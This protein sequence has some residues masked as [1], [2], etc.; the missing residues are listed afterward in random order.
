MSERGS[1]EDEEELPQEIMDLLNAAMD[2]DN[3]D[4]LDTSSSTSESSSDEEHPLLAF[5]SAPVGSEEAMDTAGPTNDQPSTSRP[6]SSGSDVSNISAAFS[7]V[8]V[9]PTRLEEHPGREPQDGEIRVTVK[10]LDDRETVIVIGQNEPVQALLDRARACFNIVTGSQKII[11][12]GRVIQGHTTIQAA[13][14]QNGNTVHI[15]ERSAASQNDRPNIT[16]RYMSGPAIP[17]HEIPAVI[18]RATALQAAADAEPNLTNARVRV[19]CQLNGATVLHTRFSEEIIEQK[20]L[21]LSLRGITGQR[22]Q[23]HL[24]PNVF[25]QDPNYILWNIKVNEEPWLRPRQS[26]EQIVRQTL[27]ELPFLPESTKANVQFKWDHRHSVLTIHFPEIMPHIASPALERMD[28]LA[29]WTEHLE[30]F[31]NKLTENDGLIAAVKQVLELTRQQRHE[32]D[33]TQAGVA[34][35]LAVLDA[36]ITELEQKWAGLSHLKDYERARFRKNQHNEDYRR[37]KVEEI[38]DSP[39]NPRYYMRHALDTELH[40]VIRHYRQQQRRFSELEELL[41]DLNQV[42]AIKFIKDSMHTTLDY[43]SRALSIFY[44][45]MQRMRHQVAHMSHLVSELDV[46]FLN[47]GCPQR[48]LPQYAPNTFSIP[49]PYCGSLSFQMVTLP[50][51]GTT[52][53]IPIREVL[54]P[55]RVL[56]DVANRINGDWPYLPYHP[57]SIFV[58]AVRAQRQPFR[59]RAMIPAGT[60][61]LGQVP[62]GGLLAGLP[63]PVPGTNGIVGI[64]V[65]NPAPPGMPQFH[66]A[67]PSIPIPTPQAG[68]DQQVITTTNPNDPFIGTSLADMM[69]ASQDTL[70]ALLNQSIPP[71]ERPGP[72]VTNVPNQRHRRVLS[73]TNGDTPSVPVE[74][75]PPPGEAARRYTTH[76]FN[77]QPDARGA[78]TETLAPF[79]VQI[80]PSELQRIA[81]NIASRYREDALRRIAAM[82]S[83]RFQD[84]SWDTRLQN[85]PMCTMRECI[86]VALELLTSSG[87]TVDESKNL[88]LALVRDEE[89]LVRAVTECVKS[90]FGRGE[91]PTHVAR[92]ILPRDQQAGART[93]YESDHL[94]EGQSDELD[95]MIVRMPSDISQP[96]S[97]DLRAIRESRMRRRQLAESRNVAGPSTSAASISSAPSLTGPSTSASSFGP[98]DTADIRNGRLPLG[99]RRVRETVHPTPARADSPSQISVTFTASNQPFMHGPFLPPQPGPSSVNL[100]QLP[101]P[102]T[103]WPNPM[104][105]LNRP[106]VSPTPTTRGLLDYDISE[107]ADQVE[108]QGHP[109]Q[110]TPSS[111]PA[112]PSTSSAGALPRASSAPN[113]S[114]SSPTRQNIM[115]QM[116]EDAARYV[117]NELGLAGFVEGTGVH[118]AAARH[119]TPVPGPPEPRRPHGAQEQAI[120]IVNRRIE[121]R[122]MVAIDPFMTCSNRLC[123]INTMATVPNQESERLTHTSIRPDEDFMR[124]VQTL[125][126]SI[127]RRPVL[128]DDQDPDYNYNLTKCANGELKFNDAPS[129]K[130][131]IRTAVRSLMAHCIDSDTVHTMNMAPIS[132]FPAACHV[133][134]NKM[135]RAHLSHRPPLTPAGEARVRQQRA[136]DEI[137]RQ[138]LE[139]AAAHSRQQAERAAIFNNLAQQP[140]PYPPFP[141]GAETEREALLAGR[142]ANLLTYIPEYMQNA[143]NPRPPGIFGMLLECTYQRLTAHDY[144][145]LA[146]HQ[147]APN[148]I[149]EF[150]AV[151]QRHIRHHYLRDRQGLTNTELYEI[152]AHIANGEEFFAQFLILNPTFPTEFQFGEDPTDML[153]VMWA[154]REVEIGFIKTLLTLATFH[155]HPRAVA[156]V[157]MKIGND[158]LYRN[159]VIFW[160][161]AGRDMNDA[162]E[163]LK[164]VSKFFANIR[165]H[166]QSVTPQDYTAFADD[167]KFVLDRYFSG[168]SEFS[169]P[170]FNEFIVKARNGTDWNEI[171]CYVPHPRSSTP[172]TEITDRISPTA[173]ANFSSAT[174]PRDLEA[175]TSSLNS[176]VANNNSSLNVFWHQIRRFFQENAITRAVVNTLQTLWTW[177]SPR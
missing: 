55:P 58:D 72:R 65:M 117:D 21:A 100:P 75:Q 57:P 85:M 135:V 172:S 44:H 82:L 97:G 165:Y 61:P 25:M 138:Q 47:P 147:S 95:G 108:E 113:T 70:E 39:R 131:F 177:L 158:Y 17:T 8:P 60:F 69:Q 120:R 140:R 134:L 51:H 67:P 137:S 155:E 5:S 153:G 115:Q 53:S 74:T 176:T 29:F 128:V 126:P 31:I 105:I 20:S 121:P 68:P 79:P 50:E 49:A 93:D 7:G 96:Q 15:V 114:N 142:V 12:S 152:A 101:M 90:L 14:I 156:T 71:I 170:A 59:V 32:N 2:T 136:L 81:K 94:E 78:E 129:F 146:R 41:D 83:A 76:R 174:S 27:Q 154:L 54:P 48:L 37:L 111:E 64:P 127:D 149:T 143:D 163:M 160:R 84:E 123:E 3:E 28:F 42:G 175:S 118:A 26:V 22:A 166:Q 89:V 35:R 18:R 43:R 45:Y 150:A 130:K 30:Y 86:A 40:D 16:G 171:D 103:T 99:R 88:M 144:A 164:R 106:V 104:D 119:V 4:G 169:E 173:S 132:G 24:H 77:V 66:P 116:L 92:L 10:A 161:M 13:G 62:Q 112:G 145:Q 107:G 148:V 87:N 73:T 141:N 23:N 52:T 167:W 63:L 162:H 46:P 122:P 139:Q 11:F 98:E 168:Y 133:E 102:P 159:M 56:S 33:M 6:T 19:P 80:E 9:A 34:E 124:H 151:I 125:L 1:Q 157:M 91:F 110:N 38:S 36:I 109:G